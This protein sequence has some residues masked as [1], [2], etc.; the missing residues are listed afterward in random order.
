MEILRRIS[1][2]LPQGGL[3]RRSLVMGGWSFVDLALGNSL[4]LAGNLILTRLLFPEAFGL[5]AMVAS[6]QIGA[7]MLSDIGIRQSIIRAESAEDPVFLRTA[8]T[9]QIVRGAAI[10]LVILACGAGLWLFGPHLATPGTVYADPVLPFLVMASALTMLLDSLVS[11]NMHLANRRME[12]RRLVVLNLVSQILGLVVMITIAS[13]H[14]TVWALL[15]GSVVSGLSRAA[16]SHVLF[17]GPRMRLAWNREY[18]DRLWQFGKW[19]IGSSGFSFLTAHADRLLLGALLAATPFSLYV[20]AGIW[21]QAYS[22]VVGMISG[23]V[24]LPVLSEVHRNRPKDLPRLF[25]KST[26]VLDA[27]C[28]AGFALFLL[29]GELL[30]AILYTP[31]Y[32]LAGQ[33]MPLMAVLILRQRFTIFT[34][35]LVLQGNTLRLMQSN[36]V[37]AAAICGAIP[38]GYMTAGTAGA[39]AASILAPLCGDAL[40]L[41]AVRRKLGASLRDDWAWLVAIPV[42]TGA[43]VAS[44]SLPF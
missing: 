33:F 11:V 20:I 3:G 1:T 2:R 10:A 26:R 32:E 13:L 37:S 43:I 34:Q 41:L 16:L 9:V 17:E 12:M 31:D 44:V 36:A 25:R 23:Q 28:L 19:L 4:R 29:G 38:L 30:I 42:L 35:L 21:I 24:G 8:W 39:I 18:R 6:I 22:M 15:V 5:M 27:A 40:K 14:A 7:Q